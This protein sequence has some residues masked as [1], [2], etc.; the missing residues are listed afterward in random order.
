[1]KSTHVYWHIYPRAQ[2]KPALQGNLIYVLEVPLVA[3]SPVIRDVIDPSERDFPGPDALGC[4]SLGHS[5]RRGIVFCGVSKA[6]VYDLMLVDPR[7]S[8][9]DTG[10]TRYNADIIRNARRFFLADPE[11]DLKVMPEP[12]AQLLCGLP[13]V[14]A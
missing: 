3:G 6:A 5:G 9:D 10:F 1:M 8:N 11:H 13:G 14:P 7:I 12:V 2:I 4:P